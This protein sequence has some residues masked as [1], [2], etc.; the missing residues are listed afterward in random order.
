M[1]IVADAAD[2][3]VTAA[4]AEAAKEV[5]AETTTVKAADAAATRKRNKS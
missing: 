5:S 3:T 1:Y 4:T 2:A